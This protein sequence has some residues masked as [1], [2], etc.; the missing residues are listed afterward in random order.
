MNIENVTNLF[1]NDSEVMRITHDDSVLYQ[2]S[3]DSIPVNP[4]FELLKCVFKGKYVYI[5]RY[6]T[7]TVSAVKNFNIS[8]AIVVDDRGIIR[9]D[10]RGFVVNIRNDSKDTATISF[11]ALESDIGNRI[12][13]AYLI[14]GNGNRS[15]NSLSATIEVRS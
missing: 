3:I 10:F 7:M 15:V 6:S 4:D 8:G 5:N 12:Y 2:W 14:D 13:T 11:Q 9:K 1:V